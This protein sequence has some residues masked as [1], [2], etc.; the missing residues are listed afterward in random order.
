MF[1]RNHARNVPP[2]DFWQII[3]CL[4]HQLENRLISLI[5]ATTYEV[6]G[7]TTAEILFSLAFYVKKVMII[8]YFEP[9]LG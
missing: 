8:D 5:S 1:P 4:T 3:P 6:M 7:V 2:C 9:D